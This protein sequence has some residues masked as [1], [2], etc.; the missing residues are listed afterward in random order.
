ML[1]NSNNSCQPSLSAHVKRNAIFMQQR[2]FLHGFLARVLELLE[3][4]QALL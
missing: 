3:M 2:T 4:Q 1:S